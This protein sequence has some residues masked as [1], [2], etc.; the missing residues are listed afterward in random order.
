MKKIYKNELYLNVNTGMNLKSCELPISI[1]NKLENFVEVIRSFSV[2]S[3][4]FSLL[5]DFKNRF[6]EEYGTVVEVPLIQ[7]LDPAGFNGLSY[8]LENQY[9]PSS[10][11]TKIT[12]IVDNKVQEALFN[13]EKRV[14]LYKDDFKNLVLNEQTNF[15]KSFDMNIMIYKDDEIKMK[16]GANFGANEAGKSFQRFSGVF[17]EDKFK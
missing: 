1:K 6:Q 12:N 8:Y 13:G 7:L 11:D 9:N 16:I 10:Q 14:Y 4:T 17:K 2:E 3:R 5:K 15:S